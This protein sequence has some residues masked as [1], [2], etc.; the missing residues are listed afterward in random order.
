MADFPTGWPTNGPLDFEYQTY[1]LLAY[2][3]RVEGSFR[4]VELYP[5]L[6]EL[7]EH[8]RQIQE[9]QTN[10]NQL[11]N[12]LPKSIRNLDLQNLKINYQEEDN[13]P[14]LKELDE[15]LGF[16]VAN[17]QVSLDYGRKCFD[18]V[19]QELAITCIGLMPLHKNDGYVF[20][21]NGDR[22][23]LQIYQ[24]SYRSFYENGERFGSLKWEFVEEQELGLLNT[25]D[26]LKLNL[27]TRFDYL[28]NPATF[29]LKSARE[30]PYEETLLPVAKRRI[31][32]ELVPKAA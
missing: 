23:F 12:A 15:I 11:S 29:W 7:I 24:F 2:L 17:M 16:A 30:L 27:I 31:L 3:Q 25:V 20:L 26:S 9:L 5:E 13:E 14:A 18:K 21:Q 1:L 4:R 19:V 8:Y 6:S 10:K 28:P 32:R 22:K